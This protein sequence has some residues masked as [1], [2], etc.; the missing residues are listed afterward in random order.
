MLMN[1]VSIII[2][3]VPIIEATN[4][5]HIIPTRLKATLP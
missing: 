5:V 4:I 3:G 2:I 1:I